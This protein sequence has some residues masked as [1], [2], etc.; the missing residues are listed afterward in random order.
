MEHAI[1][2]KSV[3][4]AREL[5]GYAA[6]G[7]IIKHSLLLRS[8]SLAALSPEDGERLKNIYHVAAVVDLRMG[9]ERDAAPDPEIPGAKNRFLPVLE[10]ADYPG[11]DPAL[12]KQFN[13]PNADRLALLK[14]SYEMGMLSDRLYVDFLFSERGK[15]AYRALFDC[16]LAL[17]EGRAC[18]WHCTD[19]KDRTGVASMLVLTALGASRETVMKDYLLTNEYNA[20]KLAAARAGLERAPLTP[21]LRELALFG[22]GAVFE[23]F[24]A[25]ALNAMDERCG[26]AEG[27]LT[28]E[29]GIGKTEQGELRRKFLE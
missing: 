7:M 10:A 23:R 27:Y 12:M 14:T 4:N 20:Q 2:L 24:M 16:L 26:S 18:L 22:S 11:Y 21:E 5:G 17:P 19:G 28:R 9:M 8:A 13:D 6:G 1:K 29:L 25:N 15:G 3:G